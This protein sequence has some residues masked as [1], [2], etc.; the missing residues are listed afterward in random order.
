MIS[1]L[2]IAEFIGCENGLSQ[3]GP[4]ISR[5]LDIFDQVERV[6]KFGG[7]RVPIEDIPPE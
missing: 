1:L 2:D 7:G 5:G 6:G 3:G 4:G